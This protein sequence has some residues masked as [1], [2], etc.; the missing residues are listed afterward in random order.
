MDDD[1]ELLCE[2]R[3]PNGL[4][5]TKPFGHEGN[6]HEFEIELP[7]HVAVLVAEHI[8]QLER[9]EEEYLRRLRWVRRSRWFLYGA[10]ALNVGACIYYLVLI[11]G[12]PR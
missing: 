8:D 11:W 6:Q 4:R 7:P 1:T 3:G 9:M 5:C 12:L 10:T 2:V